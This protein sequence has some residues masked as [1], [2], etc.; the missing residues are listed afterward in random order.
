MGQAPKIHHADRT[1]GPE[2]NCTLA[3]PVQG[4]YVYCQPYGPLRGGANATL[5]AANPQAV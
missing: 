3:S 2:S 5:L 4:F 1:V